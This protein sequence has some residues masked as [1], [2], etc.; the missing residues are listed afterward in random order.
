MKLLK[1]LE[2]Y[3][4]EGEDTGIY[5]PPDM[6]DDWHM[7]SMSKSLLKHGVGNG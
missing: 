1:G 3:I 5:I 7:D 6:R 4:A 2:K